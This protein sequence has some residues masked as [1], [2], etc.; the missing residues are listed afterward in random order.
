MRIFWY[1]GGLQIVP[2]NKRETDLLRVVTEN[3]TAKKPPEMQDC[4]PSG[5]T[6]SGDGLFEILVGNKQPRPSSHASKLNHK[7]QVICIN[8]LP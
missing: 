5:D 8:E 4:I 2:E 1:N 3:L 6:T 7:K